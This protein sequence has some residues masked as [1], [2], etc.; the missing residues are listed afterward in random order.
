MVEKKRPVAKE[1]KAKKVTEK[2]LKAKKGG[3]VVWS[4]N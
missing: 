1:K 4:P 2:E 3:A